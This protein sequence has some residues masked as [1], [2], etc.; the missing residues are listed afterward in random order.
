MAMPF[1]HVKS[2]DFF[3]PYLFSLNPEHAF[4]EQGDLV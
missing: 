4:P 2:S 3:K 1:R